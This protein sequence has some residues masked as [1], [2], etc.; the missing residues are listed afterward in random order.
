M[1]KNSQVLRVW[2]NKWN[3]SRKSNS[4]VSPR[5]WQDVLDWWACKRTLAKFITDF[6]LQNIASY[7]SEQPC[8]YATLVIKHC[9]QVT[10]N[11]RTHYLRTAQSKETTIRKPIFKCLPPPSYIQLKTSFYTITTWFKTSTPPPLHRTR[12]FNTQE[13]TSKN[14]LWNPPRPTL[15]YTCHTTINIPSTKAA[16]EHQEHYPRSTRRCLA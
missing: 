12:T 1:K 7:F 8:L 2:E 14:K 16:P 15:W 4:E 5:S 9:S 3:H 6:L 11:H 13:R 10:F